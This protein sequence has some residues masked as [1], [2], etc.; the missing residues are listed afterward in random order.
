MATAYGLDDR[1]IE[2]RVPVGSR[3]STGSAV[4]PTSYL[5]GPGGSVLGEGV[6]QQ[7]HETGYSPPTTAEVKKTWMYTS[8]PPY[9]FIT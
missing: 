1:G 7:R 8:T 5:M 3:I 4:L 2:V 9:V 6:K